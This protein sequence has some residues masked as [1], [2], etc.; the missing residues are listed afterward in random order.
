MG[1]RK[2]Q[3]S[4]FWKAL[5]TYDRFAFQIGDA[6]FKMVKKTSKK[7]SKKKKEEKQMELNLQKSWWGKILRAIQNKKQEKGKK[8]A[9]GNKKREEKS[10]LVANFFQ[11]IREKLKRLAFAG[12]LVK[13]GVSILLVVIVLLT[14]IPLLPVPGNF[15][16]LVVMSG[17]MEPTVKVGSVAVIKPAGEYKQGDIIT[18]THPND[19]NNSI[20]HRIHEV[21][22]IEGGTIF[23]TKGDANSTPDGWEIALGDIKG[24]CLF[25]IP[26]L[27]YL[28]NFAKTPKGFALM[29]IVP[30]VLIILDEL[31][32]IKSELTK[33]IEAKYENKRKAQN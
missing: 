31:R 7:I 8:K 9:T 14:V 1:N 22:E 12:S 18:F 27:G 5:I 17:S 20:T 3:S 4:L 25:S 16:T 28:V 32:V 21:K 13:Y 2:S 29:I 6:V 26:F 30:A 33:Q 19:P 24:K 15:Q 11:Q 23:I 10:A